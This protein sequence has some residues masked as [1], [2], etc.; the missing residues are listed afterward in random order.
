MTA[1][2]GSRVLK[3]GDA[4]PEVEELQIRLTGFEGT[5]PDGSYAVHAGFAM[6]LGAVLIKA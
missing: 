4:F 3:K 6:D 2:F 5:V 1:I